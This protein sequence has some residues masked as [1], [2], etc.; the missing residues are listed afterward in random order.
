MDQ[1]LRVYWIPQVGACEPFYIPV[2]D[3]IEAKKVMD[4]LAAYDAFQL[5]NR[6][7]PDYVN[8]G[9]LQIYDDVLEEWEEWELETE[10][11]WFDNVDEYIE[12]LSCND[13]KVRDEINMLNKGLFS[14]IDWEKID[15]MTK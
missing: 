13:V 1:K 14:Q 2:K 4:I 10:D 11:E 7:K 15:R 8:T 6:I 12:H 3:V 9:G 5:Q